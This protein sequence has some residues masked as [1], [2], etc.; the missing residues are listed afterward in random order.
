[1]KIPESVIVKYQLTSS[2]A[3]HIGE[4]FMRNLSL[5]KS[6]LPGF[7]SIAFMECDFAGKPSDYIHLYNK[8]NKRDANVTPEYLDDTAIDLVLQFVS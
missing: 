8:S 2:G 1:M 5:F 6:N 3:A 7:E 4:A